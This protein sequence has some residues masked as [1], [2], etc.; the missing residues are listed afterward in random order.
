MEALHYRLDAPHACGGGYS[1]VAATKDLLVG[2]IAEGAWS[3]WCCSWNCCN[4]GLAS[5]GGSYV[6]VATPHSWK[7][8][9]VLEVLVATPHG[10]RGGGGSG[11]RSGRGLLLMQLDWD[12]S[13]SGPNTKEACYSPSVSPKV[14]ALQERSPVG[15]YQTHRSMRRCRQV[16]SIGPD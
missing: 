3:G 8:G 6:I 11:S 5:G 7:I 10:C 1:I 12:A 4:N 2:T 13:C 9:D 16:Q 14:L 15:S